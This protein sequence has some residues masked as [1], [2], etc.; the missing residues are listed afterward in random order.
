[1]KIILASGSPRRKELLEMLQVRHLGTIPAKGEERG[2]PER[3]PAGPVRA[4]SRTGGL[5]YKKNR[6]IKNYLKEAKRLAISSN[7]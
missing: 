5:C 1:M 7:I 4:R 6:M 3:G 2:H